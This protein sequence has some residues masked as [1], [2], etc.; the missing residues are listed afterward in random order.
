MF[1]LVGLNLLPSLGY[2]QLID[3]LVIDYASFAYQIH[4]AA[5]LHCSFDFAHLV[6]LLHH[7]HFKDGD[8][9]SAGGL[10]CIL[11]MQELN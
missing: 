7:E 8:I 3:K 11:E 2:P 10:V 1:F 4:L 9:E 6:W 5:N